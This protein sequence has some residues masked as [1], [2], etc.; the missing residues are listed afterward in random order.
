MPP[1]LVEAL[2]PEPVEE[3]FEASTDELRTSEGIWPSRNVVPHCVLTPVMISVS[4]AA[5]EVPLEEEPEPMFM[6]AGIELD[7][8]AAE[9]EAEEAVWF[10]M[11]AA[12]ASAPWIC[13]DE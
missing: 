7:A 13:C 11:A 6:P 2:E 5:D 12:A 10:A 9:E 4:E 3:E 1:L 8:A